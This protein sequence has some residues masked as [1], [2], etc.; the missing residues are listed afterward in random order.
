MHVGAVP[1]PAFRTTVQRRWLLTVGMLV[2]LLQG[3]LFAIVNP[4]LSGWHPY[5]GHATV[6]GVVPDHTHPWDHDHR[7]ANGFGEP[8]EVG[9]TGVS[10]IGS[11]AASA[12][13]VVA[14]LAL[15]GAVALILTPIGAGRAPAPPAP[16]PFDPPPRS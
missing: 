7:D 2:A 14:L 16:D 9:F 3:S 15:A 11:V 6:G 4:D 13:P 1:A 10:D 5:H 12:V 8:A